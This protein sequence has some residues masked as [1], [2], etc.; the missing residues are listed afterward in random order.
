[1]LLI[2]GTILTVL[3]DSTAGLALGVVALRAFGPLAIP[4]DR[5]R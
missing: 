3:L 1:V 5:D 4:P 2:A